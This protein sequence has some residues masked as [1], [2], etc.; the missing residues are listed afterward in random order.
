MTLK[1]EQLT[2]HGVLSGPGVDAKV[3]YVVRVEQIA[4]PAGHHDDP[5]A[6]ARPPRITADVT[7]ADPRDERIGRFDQLTLTL[8][9][10]RRVHAFH[11]GNGRLS[12]RGGFFT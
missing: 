11:N 4:V 12:V 9:D 7:F 1:F 3:S 10:G 6:P 2:G 8:A 5:S